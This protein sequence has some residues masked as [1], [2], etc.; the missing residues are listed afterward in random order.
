MLP[1]A[2]DARIIRSGDLEIATYQIGDPDAPPV[3]LVHGFASS[4]EANWVL[5]GWSRE[6]TRAGHRVIALDHR[7]HGESDKPHDRSAYSMA[8]MRDDVFRAMDA[9][10][11][12]TAPW[13]GYSMGARVSWFAALTEPERVTRAVLGGIPKADPFARLDVVQARRYTEMGLPITDAVTRTYLE[14][15]SEQRD[16]D[17]VALVA[18]VEGLRGDSDAEIDEAPTQPLLIAAGSEDA[19]AAEARDL[20]EGTTNAR[21]LE[22]PGRS[23]FNAPTSGLFRRTALEFL[24]EDA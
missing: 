1:S 17:L 22:L 19:I 11:I 13:I 21:F 15:A 5:T 23:H 8:L 6:L 16:N 4:A 2:P 24:R 18:L 3:V 10:G 7:A 14:M 12:G 20:A 9:Y